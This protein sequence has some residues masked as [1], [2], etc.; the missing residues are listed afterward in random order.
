MSQDVSA[1]VNNTNP[2]RSCQIL[3]AQ[4]QVSIANAYNDDISNIRDS[5]DTL[6]LHG[7]GNGE[8]FINQV[9]D[10][11]LLGAVWYHPDASINVWQWRAT[12]RKCDITLVKK[13]CSE[14]KVKVTV[15]FLATERLTR[16]EHRFNYVDN[17]FL[18]ESGR[19]R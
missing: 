17:L 10:N 19:H 4:S 6:T 13:T 11:P 3:D 18:L 5:N 12:E 1:F 15:A 8:L 2:H 16:I 7:M 9:A 14:L